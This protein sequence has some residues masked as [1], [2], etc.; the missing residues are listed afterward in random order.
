VN[1]ITPERNEILCDS[2]LA[3]TPDRQ[4]FHLQNHWNRMDAPS[5]SIQ[6]LPN[7]K[8]ESFIKAME[9]N[10]SS[11]LMVDGVKPESLEMDSMNVDYL[12]VGARS[13]YAMR[14]LLGSVQARTVILDSSWK[15]WAWEKALKTMP[16]DLALHIVDRDGYFKARL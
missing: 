6:P 3:H 1:I 5:V 7:G 12:I 14:E 16:E 8:K 13:R 4:Q 9:V 11:I 2:I 15:P 10:G